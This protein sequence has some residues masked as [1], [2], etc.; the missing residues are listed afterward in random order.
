MLLRRFKK[1]LGLKVTAIVALSIAFGCLLVL[2]A[3]I[4]REVSYDRFHSK[5][6]RIFRI[7]LN[8]N[9][10]LPDARIYGNW[11]DDAK[12]QMPE[13]E[14]VLRLQRLRQAIVKVGD[15]S[16]LLDNGFEVDS[17][18]FSLFDF[19]IKEKG[20][21]L[22]LNEPSEVVIS[23]S[24]AKKLFGTTAALGKT[25]SI[26]SRDYYEPL[27][28]TVSAVMD[29]YPAQSHLHADMLI[30]RNP[31]TQAFYYTYL[32][33]SSAEADSTV[34]QKVE[35]YLKLQ[36]WDSTY[37][38]GVDLQ[39]ITDIHLHSAKV[40]EL[41]PNGSYQSFVMLVSAVGLILLIAL[42]NLMNSS[43]IISLVNR[44][45]YALKHTNGATKWNL[46]AEDMGQC[47]LWSVL[48]LIGGFWSAYHIGELTSQHIFSIPLW[49]GLAVTLG[50]GLM[51]FVVML[52]PLI[53]VP[54]TQLARL[55]Q[56]GD[57]SASRR[58]VGRT[59]QLFIVVQIALSLFVVAVT[60]GV[61]QQI[62][63]VL[64]LQLGSGQKGIIVLDNQTMP[65]VQNFDRLKE[66]LLA[67]PFIEG[68][69]AAMEPPA[70]AVR[71]KSMVKLNG[72]Q[73]E[74][75][76]DILCVESDFF[77]FFNVTLAAGNMLPVYPYTFDWEQ[78]ALNRVF[79]G[80]APPDFVPAEPYSDR[81]LI[82][83]AAAEL[84]GFSNVA[85]AVGQ[86]IDMEH[87]HLS[88]IPGGTI[89][90]VVDRIG[91]TSMY[92]Q[93]RPT[94]IVQRRMFTSTFL[95]RYAPQH[96]AEAL[97]ALST[98]WK[99]VN[100]TIPLSYQFLD[101]TYSQVYRNELQ[102]RNFLRYFSLLCLLIASLGLVVTISFLTKRRVKEIAIRKTLG[103][104]SAQMVLMLNGRILKWVAVA[105]VLAAPAAYYVVK[106]WQQA[107]A[108]QA[109][110]SWWLF[111]VAAAVVV[112][113]ALLTI[114]G[115][116][117]RAASRNP[118]DGLKYE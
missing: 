24:L 69:T 67:H 52:L 75:G 8:P 90:G 6:N 92:E 22:L 17:T 15:D 59:M 100:P 110:F 30:K 76:L 44:D 25:L 31:R 70:G 98:V 71:D 65:V 27:N 94:L 62:S 64:G 1:S 96:E 85:E 103:A 109:T 77:S 102:T 82:N 5:A 51:L 73:I 7:T 117:Y 10:G 114:S 105:F 48:I 87:Q 61:S 81:F 21:E 72:K 12:P 16:Y 9:T 45:Y 99:E 2:S 14:E 88:I 19:D 80:A 39:P 53:M 86:R 20:R 13:I 101:D 54:T 55:S 34:E 79:T 38:K 18:F 104:T 43:R 66:A 91:Y 4:H 115:I 29:D 78:I 113:I 36:G 106:R 3:Y 93:E 97:A 74:E 40:R 112:T 49:L 23:E 84:M 35:E 60:L 50:F 63:H 68:V 95:V 118:V 28:L 47:L 42:I 108:Y 33:L 58:G 41:E 56:G 57:T 116:T 111:I 26:T 107:F 11:I 37:L 83:R 89:A 32:L 46:I